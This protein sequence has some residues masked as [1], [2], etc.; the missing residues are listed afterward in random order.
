MV[1]GV[2]RSVTGSDPIKAAQILFSQSKINFMSVIPDCPGAAYKWHGEPVDVEFGFCKIFRND[3]KKMWWY[4]FECHLADVDLTKKG[5]VCRGEADIPAIKVTP[6]K[7]DFF[8]LGNH[9]GIGIKKLVAGGWPDHQHFSL[10]CFTF[11]ADPEFRIEVF[12]QKSFDDHE[13][14]RREFQAK[15]APAEFAKMEAMEKA[16]REFRE[17]H[18]K[19]FPG[20]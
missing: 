20:L 3:E 19:A 8:V 18:P 16:M 13:K 15:H 4:N 10:P 17:K 2:S 1:S 5:E 9:F 14:A 11:Q 12:D 7:G 6:R